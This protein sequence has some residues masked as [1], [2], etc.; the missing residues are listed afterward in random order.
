MPW[1]QRDSTGK[2]KGVYARQQ[3]E[4]AD[5]FLEEGSEEVAAFL[6]GPVGLVDP[7]RD[8]ERDV[9]SMEAALADGDQAKFNE[10]ALKIIRGDV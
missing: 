9:K 5:E 10:L 2:V 8:R 1:I 7:Q 6:R 4:I 3:P